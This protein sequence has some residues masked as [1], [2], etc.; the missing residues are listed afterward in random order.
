MAGQL[1]GMLGWG[2]C[3]TGPDPRLST[4]CFILTLQVSVGS[5]WFPH[6]R[7]LTENIIQELPF[8][9]AKVQ[10]QESS[11]APPRTHSVFHPSPGVKWGL[12]TPNDLVSPKT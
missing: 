6:D 3:N 5:Q 12:L 2:C 8:R 10:G 9:D 4:V 11:E 1:S 7:N